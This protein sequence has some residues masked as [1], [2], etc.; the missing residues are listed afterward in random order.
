MKDLPKVFANKIKDDINNT[1][2]LF[3]GSDR[4]IK[5]KRDDI[6]VVKK[7]NNIFSSPNHVYKSR[8]KIILKDNEVEKIIVGKNNTHIITIDGELIKIIDIDDISRM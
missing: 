5:K 7:I 8:V 2:D 3:Y 1:Q 4:N 6:G